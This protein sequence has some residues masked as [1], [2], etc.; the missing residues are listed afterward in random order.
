MVVYQ[1]GAERA[2]P[3]VAAAREFR[4]SAKTE[5]AVKLISSRYREYAPSAPLRPWVRALF[6][7]AAG[8][9]AEAECIRGHTLEIA[10]RSGDPL[11]SN[12]FADAHASI[13]CCIGGTYSIEDLWRPSRPGAHVIGP[14]GRARRTTPGSSFT[15]VGAY[16][17][18]SGARDF[19]E[20]PV[21][22][23]AD[24]VVALEELWGTE[25]I[26]LEE[27]MGE[28]MNDPERVSALEATLLR[29]LK[30]SRRRRPRFDLAQLTACVQERGGNL[31]V[32]TM[33][34]LA[35][36][37]RQFLSR[38]FQDETGVNPK[39]YA[40]L[41]RFQAVLAASST[42]PRDWADLAARVG[43]ADQ[44]HM[45]ADFRR[46]SGSTPAKLTRSDTFHPFRQ[47]D[48]GCSVAAGIRR[49]NGPLAD[50][51]ISEL[52]P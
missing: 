20:F 18:A 47:R 22:E 10:R 30:S 3:G 19:L 15:Q 4:T 51:P 11:W 29:R 31:S 43:Y 34:G 38:T 1:A 39:L 17:T 49:G 35:G 7:F 28:A 13:V 2:E 6:T 40:R 52:K 50:C 33:A 24:R 5:S 9:C 14:M 32:E 46:F 37:S 23:V 48:N 27:R 44:S 21:C 8:G 26:R 41:A 42:G 45:I 25:A 16:L 36:V 12:L